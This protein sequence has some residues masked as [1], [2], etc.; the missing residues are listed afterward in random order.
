MN[1]D[2]YLAH[3]GI[4]GM[5]WGVR[6]YRNYDGTLTREGIKRYSLNEQSTAKDVKRALKVF[7]WKNFKRVGQK[8]TD[9]LRNDKE[10]TKLNKQIRDEKRKLD[11]V[12][13]R[14][15]YK[16]D[17]DI[18][19][20][21]RH[22]EVQ[23]RRAT[24]Y[25]LNK[26]IDERE[27]KV[28]EEWVAKFNDARLKDLNYTGDIEVGRKLLSKYGGVTYARNGLMISNDIFGRYSY[29]SEYHGYRSGH[30]DADDY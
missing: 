16:Y 1:K 30:I 7:G 26:K 19:L 23:D 22:P 17:N 3:H 15:S 4:L 5:K 8:Y 12:V 27:A 21:Y 18:D 24:I 29:N 25:Q 6:R 20:V 28:S 14:L 13:Y 10:L 2:A 11:N 9:A